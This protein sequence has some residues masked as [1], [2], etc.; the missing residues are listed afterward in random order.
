MNS[1][2]GCKKSDSTEP[3]WHGIYACIRYNR[4]LFLGRFLTESENMPPQ[5]DLASPVQDKKRRK[6]EARIIPGFLFFAFLMMVTAERKKSR[7]I[8]YGAGFL[9]N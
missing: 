2:A 5:P 4:S 7:L 6:G 3:G 8:E 1:I 9:L